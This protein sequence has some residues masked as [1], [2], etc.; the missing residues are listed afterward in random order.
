MQLTTELEFGSARLGLA[1]GTFRLAAMITVVPLGRFA[2][3]IGAT[4][5]LRIAALIGAVSSLGVGLLANS[6]GELVLWLAVG[7]VGSALGQPAANRLVVNAVPRDRQ[8]LGFGI[9]QASQPGATMLA[10][11]SVPLIAVTLGWR[12]AFIIAALLAVL[13][14][15]AARG[16]ARPLPQPIGSQPDMVAGR[17]STLVMLGF[18][19]AMSTATSSSLT[20]FA[21]DSGVR[22]GTPERFAGLILAVA[23]V[24]AIVVRIVSGWACDRLTSNHLIISAVLMGTGAVGLGLLATGMPWATFPGVV[25]GLSGVWGLSAVFWFS[26]LRLF[27]H[28]P[29][30]ITG[31]LA[32]GADV[33]AAVGPFLFGVT[34]QGAGFSTA[35]MLAASMALL[36]TVLMLLA[37][38]L[39]EG[40]NRTT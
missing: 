34:A 11:L 40:R 5:A 31:A 22:A 12:A 24:V 35:W 27:P 9:K 30:R 1:A 14:A 39:V 2:D 4:R 7:G 37:N 6:W 25:L 13:A 21:V 28:R 36:G 10:G 19:F 18:A 3:R 16:R 38:R 15:I 20:T 32:P 23:S 17:R 8:G 33:G 29:G 26:V